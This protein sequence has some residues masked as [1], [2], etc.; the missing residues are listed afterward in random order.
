MLGALLTTVAASGIFTC[1]GAVAPPP[2]DGPPP[3]DRAFKRWDKNCDDV[4]DQAEFRRG[5][6]RVA[7]RLGRVC[8]RQQP[9]PAD[10][11]CQAGEDRR[12]DC[13]ALPPDQRGRGPGFGHGRF[14]G[15]VQQAVKRAIFDTL[16]R[17]RPEIEAM[18]REAAEQAVRDMAG[19]P[20]DR[21]GERPGRFEG[22]QGPW[23]RR[24]GKPFAVP[25]CQRGP[26]GPR[27]GCEAPSCA[28]EM[29][30]ECQPARD[31]PEGRDMLRHPAPPSEGAGPSWRHRG[32]GEM[33]EPG[34][35]GSP[36]QGDEPRDSSEDRRPGIRVE[37]LMRLFDLNRDGEITFEEFNQV[38][39]RLQ[40]M[41]RD[42]DGKLD[43]PD[44][45]RPPP[46]R[47]RQRKQDA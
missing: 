13:S 42:H 35:S 24:I 1:L 47:S 21:P 43:R 4:I 38:L 45:G 31:R 10:R 5:V 20:E 16:A 25:E 36:L 12:P 3:L 23:E 9:G 7:E 15:R 30:P 22:R 32:R 41:D 44:Q 46:P 11:T 39:K 34:R 2:C 27:H 29:K 8:C 18:I 19:P 14:Q 40:A 28:F 33:R 37:R 17:H 26:Q 6:C